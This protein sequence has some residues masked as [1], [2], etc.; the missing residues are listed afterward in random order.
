LPKVDNPNSSAGNVDIDSLPIS[1]CTGRT[2]FDV[3]KGRLQNQG[4]FQ[5]VY[6]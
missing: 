3:T 5:G 2:D 4:Y 1:M 6:Y